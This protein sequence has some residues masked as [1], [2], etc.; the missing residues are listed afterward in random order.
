MIRGDRD[1]IRLRNPTEDKRAFRRMLTSADRSVDGICI[2]LLTL[3]EAMFTLHRKGFYRKSV[4]TEE[5][6]FRRDFCYGAKLSRADLLIA[7]PRLLDSEE[8]AKGN[9]M[10]NKGGSFLPF[11]FHVRAFSI[12][13]DPSI[14][15]PGTG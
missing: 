4:H 7:C 9:G 13:S 14:S 11:Y 5:R 3:T 12:P 6:K 1:V 8:D 10:R 2:K 15:E